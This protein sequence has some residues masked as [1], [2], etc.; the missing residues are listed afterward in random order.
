MKLGW[1]AADKLR[2]GCKKGKSLCGWVERKDKTG[3]GGKAGVYICDG[4]QCKVSSQD[5]Q[6]Y[7]GQCDTGRPLTV[8]RM[9]KKS[10]NDKEYKRNDVIP[11]CGRLCY[12]KIFFYDERNA[13]EERER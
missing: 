12:L 10:Q 4:L 8:R 1:K 13:K 5:D 9:D 7:R 3:Q 11:L 2:V 6:R